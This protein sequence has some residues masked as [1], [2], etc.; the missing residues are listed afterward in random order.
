M[1]IQRLINDATRNNNKESGKVIIRWHR[2]FE[3][4]I[5]NTT[6]QT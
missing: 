1:R 3:N 2:K 6:E 4:C 5:E